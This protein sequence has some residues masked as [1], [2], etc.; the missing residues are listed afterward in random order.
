MGKRTKDSKY[1]P[2]Q[3]PWRDQ[4]TFFGGPGQ[5]WT[6]WTSWITVVIV[7][8][9][10]VGGIILIFSTPHQGAGPAGPAATAAAGHQAAPGRVCPVGSSTTDVP[11]AAP[12]D[13]RWKA[14]YG[15]T[16]PYSP[17]VGP[18]RTVDGVAQCFQHSPMG[19][20]LAGV[21]ILQSARTVDLVSAQKII[22]TQFTPGKGQQAAL[23]EAVKA[24]STAPQARVFGRVVGFKIESYRPE[25]AVVLLVESWPQLGQYTGYDLT[26]DWV[27][28]DWRVHFTDNGQPSLNGV[29]TV[30]PAGYTPWE[31]AG[32]TR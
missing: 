6:L 21:N 7:G 1:E 2:G 19:A 11:A 27:N 24:A 20:A 29:I 5:K 12:A 30:D 15:N 13:I 18:T 26:L 9:V 3:R 23:S 16:W 8:V 22:R 25:Q 10:C 17:S 28:G 31:S 14:L 4:S 32:G